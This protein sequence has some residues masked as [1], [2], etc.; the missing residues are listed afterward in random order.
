[1]N[2]LRRS[3]RREAVEFAA[4]HGYEKLLNT[5][6]QE[7]PGRG[8]DLRGVA[9][10]YSFGGGHLELGNR[11][12]EKYGY[13][14]SYENYVKI[15]E[16]AAQ[17]GFPVLMKDMLSKVRLVHGVIAQPAARGLGEAL[18]KNPR[19]GQE[20]FR[21][22]QDEINRM[23]SR[24]EI[25]IDWKSILTGA[26]E[27]GNAGIFNK[28]LSRVPTGKWQLNWAPVLKGAAAGGNLAIIREVL[29]YSHSRV[30]EFNEELFEG[31]KHG[32]LEVVKDALLRGAN[33]FDNALI[34]AAMRG[35]VDIVRLLISRGHGSQASMTRDV[36]NDALI[37]AA[38]NRHLSV[39]RE[40][41]NAGAN[42][43]DRALMYAPKTGPLSEY[44]VK[45]IDE[46]W[47][48]NIQIGINRKIDN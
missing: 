43:L 14:L 28:L 31:A 9:I 21:I 19:G 35:Y 39:V 23:G 30:D 27:S 40:L 12:M 8:E 33:K 34:Q 3:T 10:D 38:D 36:L 15:A 41:V 11:L 48:R 16:L 24:G 42:S 6:L 44:L 1:M 47:E 13:R 4:L 37:E 25:Y 45:E 22:L 18:L 20:Q 5:L 32:H 7:N 29:K 26:A 17:N 2:K 46:K